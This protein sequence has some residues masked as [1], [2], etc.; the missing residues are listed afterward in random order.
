MSLLYLILRASLYLEKLLSGFLRVERS[1][2]H[3]LL[4]KSAISGLSPPFE[5][6]ETINSPSLAVIKIMDAVRVVSGGSGQKM[7]KI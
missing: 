4:R 7:A 5:L 3:F 2:H 6:P 1:I